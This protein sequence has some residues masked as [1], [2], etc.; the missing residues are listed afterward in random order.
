MN[1]KDN[2]YLYVVIFTCGS[3]VGYFTTLFSFFDIEY[4]V[5]PFDFLFQ[6]STPL[7][8]LYLSITLQNNQQKKQNKYTFWFVKLEQQHNE[9]ALFFNK[10]TPN[11]QV[12][13][14]EVI[15][16]HKSMTM[17]LNFL[18]NVFK[19]DN[20]NLRNLESCKQKIDRLESV[21]VNGEVS[22]NNI[23]IMNNWNE[24]NSIAIEINDS[25]ISLFNA[26]REVS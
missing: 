23:L 4:K 26:L 8:I 7:L 10:I 16:W 2:I 17:Q 24:I 6:L 14:H 20:E 22:N 13:I 1:H 11:G 21:L 15:K 19:N 9:F 12:P 3:L 5:N 25:Y 18:N